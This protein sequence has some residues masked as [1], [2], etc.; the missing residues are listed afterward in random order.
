MT[1]IRLLGIDLDGTLLDSRWKLS[2]ANRAALE[3]AHR[4]GVHIVFVT[5]RRYHITHPITRAFDFPHYIVTTAGAVTRS[6]SGNV[7]FVQTLPPDIT[8]ELLSHIPRFRP[9][10][11]LI[12]DVNGREDLVCENPCMTNIHVARY[13]ELNMNFMLQV[14]DLA[15]AVTDA[16]IEVVLMGHVNE[17]REALSLIDGFHRRSELNVL[18]TEYLERDLCLLDVIDARTH[19]G[20]AVRRLA[21]SLDVPQGAVMAIGDNHSDLDMLAYAAVPVVMGNGT[22][23]LKSQGWYVTESNDQDG[24]AKALQRFILL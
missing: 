7:L 20:F 6:S 14:P 15:S 11:F 5:G 9:F 10:S 3:Q 21:A 19:K 8:K 12:A 17:M 2:E 13:V 24:V 1:N 22:D 4:R 18:R 23:E 16:T